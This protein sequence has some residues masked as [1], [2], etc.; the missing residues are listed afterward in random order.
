MLRI[1]DL[2]TVILELSSKCNAR[3]PFC[4]R[5]DKKRPY[6]PADITYADFLR[7]PEELFATLRQLSLAGNFGDFCCNA[8][9]PCIAAR[10]IALAPELRLMG[11]TNGSFQPASW[12]AELGRSFA[13]GNSQATFALDGL[14]DTHALHRKGTDFHT[15]LRNAEAFAAAGGVAYWKFIVFRHNEHQLDEAERIARETGFAR[16]YAIPSRYYDHE[17][18]PPETV[19]Y[20]TKWDRMDEA[21]EALE[22]GGGAGPEALC[23]PHHKSRSI[24]IGADGTVLP[25]CFAHVQHVTEYRDEFRF[26]NELLGEHLDELNMK[27]RPLA[28][29]LASPFFDAVL[30]AS[31]RNPFCLTKC[32]PAVKRIK[33]DVKLRDVCF[34]EDCPE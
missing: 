9:A 18:H 24:Y 3:C 16:F 22:H 12:W 29:I 32:N 30:A 20:A 14:A 17:L 19:A 27:S 26:M 23:K 25:C 5:L 33:K 28:D 13:N 1:A 10:A 2:K 8:D 31:R 11:D 7:L 6:P 21:R 15:V 4:S 34:F